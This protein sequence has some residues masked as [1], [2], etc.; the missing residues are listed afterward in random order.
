MIIKMMN[1]SN[2]RFSWIIDDDSKE[3]ARFNKRRVTVFGVTYPRTRIALD[4]GYQDYHD[5]WNDTLVNI[6]RISKKKNPEYFI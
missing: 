2:L 3:F 1:L 6:K 4:N 5:Y